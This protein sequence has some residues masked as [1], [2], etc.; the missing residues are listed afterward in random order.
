[1]SLAYHHHHHHYHVPG[2]FLCTAGGFPRGRGVVLGQ[3]V[4]GSRLPE[5]CLWNRTPDMGR[6]AEI[7]TGGRNYR[8]W[9]A[10]YPSEAAVWR[11]A[12]HLQCCDVDLPCQ[13]TQVFLV[14][15]P[16]H[17]DHHCLQLHIFRFPGPA[18]LWGSP[19]NIVVGWDLSDLLWFVG[20]AEGFAA[21]WTTEHGCQKRWIMWPVSTSWLWLVVCFG[22]HLLWLQSQRAVKSETAVEFKV[23]SS[24]IWAHLEKLLFHLLNSK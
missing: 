10:S 6:T 9:P 17:C 24:L 1:M 12:F 15:H 13:S 7:Q 11:P 3:T 8:L 23:F 18:D 5:G 19:D 4:A 16:N 22:R 2:S 20:T 21:G 14:L